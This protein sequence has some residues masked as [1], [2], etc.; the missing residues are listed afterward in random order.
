[1][2][3]LLLLLVVLMFQP[4]PKSLGIPSS[5]K[6]WYA[7]NIWA[8]TYF[9]GRLFVGTGNSSNK[10]PSGNAGPINIWTYSD[11]TGWQSEF[12]VDEEQIDRIA[13]IDG[14]LTIPGHDSREG[15]DFG[16]WY[17]READGWV[18]HRNIPEAVHVY[19]I[20]TYDGY[21]FAGI[22]GRRPRDGSIA[23]STDHGESWTLQ[24][25]PG[26]VNT[27][28]KP[29]TGEDPNPAIRNPAGRVYTFFTIAGELYANT[30]PMAEV[31]C[32]DVGGI[33]GVNIQDLQNAHHV[34]AVQ[35]TGQHFEPARIDLFGG[36]SAN[37]VIY[38]TVFSEKT[39][40]IAAETVNDHQWVPVGL[41]AVGADL[42]PQPLDVPSCQRP[43]D[44][45]IYDSALYILC[46]EPTDSGWQMNVMTSCD[47]QSWEIGRSLRNTDVCAVICARTGGALCRSWGRHRCARGGTGGGGRG[48]SKSD[49]ADQQLRRW[50]RRVSSEV[51]R[52]IPLRI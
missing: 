41:F 49:F 17:A 26:G 50:I 38:P 51:G 39:V 48:A 4:A 30:V 13:V 23:V 6:G 12:T 35:W 45:K 11:D 18:K 32:M 10:A 27:G 9:D 37:R 34:Y 21:M 40:Y 2:K 14:T 46:N 8:M 7:R 36:T 43:Q 25:I 24:V 52:A 31:A 29:C 33:I 28:G 5:D 1:M 20:A 22:D 42:A 3:T 47:L 15:W 16:N 44:I 19:D